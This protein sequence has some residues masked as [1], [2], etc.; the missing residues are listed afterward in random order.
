MMP[1]EGKAMSNHDHDAAALLDGATAHALG[2]AMY[3]AVH[4]QQQGAIIRQASTTMVCTALL[5]LGV[6]EAAEGQPLPPPADDSATPA[7]AAPVAAAVAGAAANVPLPAALAAG[8]AGH[9]GLAYQSIAQSAALAIQDAAD[10]LRN[11]STIASTAA[12]VAMAQYL[13]NPGA[14]AEFDAAMA[15]TQ[16]LMAAAVANFEAIGACAENTLKNFPDA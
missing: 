11:V 4:A 9:G 2:L 1:G 6:A 8:A 14:S 12:G 13:A 3:S 5:S 15:G 16:Q 7:P 10:Y